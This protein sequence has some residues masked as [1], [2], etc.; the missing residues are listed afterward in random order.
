MPV[1]RHDWLERPL[2]WLASSNIQSLHPPHRG[3]VRAWIDERSGE[4]A[5]W[6]PEITGYFVTL[7]VKLV[8][9]GREE[10]WASRARLAAEWL[11]C[12]ALDESGAV[13]GRI[14]DDER[15]ARAD[16][17]SRLHGRTY[18]FNCGTVGLGF[19]A[20]HE[21]TAERR[22]LDAA[23]RVARACLEMFAAG[24]RFA[25]G[26]DLRR[27]IP[28]FGDKWS[29]HFGAFQLKASM[30]LGEL[31]RQ[32]GDR[33]LLRFAEHALES[34]LALQEED[35]RFPTDAS[36][37]HTHLHPHFYAT[38]GLL[39]LARRQ[40][41]HDLIRRCRM[42]VDW[43]LR[44]CLDRAD[45]I[46]EWSANGTPPLHGVRSDTLL[47]ALR[48]REMLL[49]IDPREEP[50]ET[51]AAWARVEAICDGLRL[52]SG[53]MAYGRDEHGD[54]QAHANSWCTFFAIDLGLTR[55]SRATA[56][57]CPTSEFLII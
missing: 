48:A 55:E 27:R 3:G 13:L 20:L 30:F 5:Y 15:D 46:Q 56:Q 10:P 25:A 28:L 24:G 37:L 53:A 4:P 8:R 57:R 36:G 42:A 19:L 2:H 50:A 16:S 54:K 26:Y 38:E 23:G 14:Y 35:G 7:C 32:S 11:E 47:Q 43:A 44:R 22:W 33:E 17:R 29:E 31:G 45:P 6:Y 39:W 41:R 9:S 21:L 49:W 12:S 18:L 52:P 34:T 40:G 1:P 51:R